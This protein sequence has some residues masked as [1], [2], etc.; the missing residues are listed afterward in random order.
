MGGGKMCDQRK[1]RFAYSHD[2]CPDLVT[3]PPLPNWLRVDRVVPYENYNLRN[4]YNYWTKLYWATPP[5]LTKEMREV[6]LDLYKRTKEE[7][8]V[9]HIVPLKSPDV[10]GLHVPWN[11]EILGEKQ[12]LAKGNRWWPDM[13]EEQLTLNL[14]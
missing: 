4:S 14:E 2:S 6:I 1:G 8:H 5:W 7:E 10:C 3:R 9:D 12:N 11:L 13:W